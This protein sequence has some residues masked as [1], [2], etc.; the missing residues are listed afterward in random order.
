M[1]SSFRTFFVSFAL[2]SATLF[3]YEADVDSAWI[4]KQNGGRTELNDGT[5]EPN[6]DCIGDGCGIPEKAPESTAE[7]TSTS[8]S[9]EQNS[10]ETACAGDGCES[11]CVGDGCESATTQDG[12][13][14]T[15]KNDEY[16][17]C[18]PADSLLPECNDNAYEEDEDDGT[19]RFIQDNSEVA[20]ARKEGFSKGIQLGFRV[21]GGTNMLLGK[22]ADDWNL[23]IEGGAGILAR[24]SLIRDLSVQLELNFTYRHFSY[25]SETDYAKNEATVDMMLF[26]IPTMFHYALV[27]DFMYVGIGFNL[28]LKLDS[29]SEF[30]QTVDTGKGIEK[31]KR[32]NTI[33]TAGVQ[34]GG[35]IDLSF[36]LNKFMML[37][38]R[39]V[40]NFT[41]LLNGKAVAETSVMKSK[42]YTFHG[43][44]GLAFLL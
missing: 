34:A 24:L 7:N 17:D 28:G 11:A 33:P 18:T 23:G 26:E 32:D 9:G 30:K 31:D 2:L 21:A 40:Q 15:A 38:L 8:S 22:K 35:L 4:A 20:K 10:A 25:E 16:E 1:F 27:E 6:P 14:K 43:T 41:E 44:V 5:N 29:E 3:A 39:A 36:A 12:D 13:K 19:G 42:L 37:N